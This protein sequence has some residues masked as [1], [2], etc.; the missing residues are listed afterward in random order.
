MKNGGI[1]EMRIASFIKKF[2]KTYSIVII[3]NSNDSIKKYSLKAPF[4]KI[5]AALLIIFTLSLSAYCINLSRDSANIKEV[6]KEA[7]QKQ[8]ETL[9]L[10]IVEQNKALAESNN[11]IKSLQS[12][13]TENKKKIKEFSKMYMEI[14]NKYISKSNRG[15]T[16]KSKSESQTGLDLL[17]L[18]S[19]IQQINKNLDSD[20]DLA[21]DL[22][23]SETK[24]ER[25]VNALPTSVPALGKVT[26]PFGMRMHPIKKVYKTHEGVD[27]SSSKGDP[28]H[29][30][31][32]GIVVYSGY[33]SG[34]GKYVIIDHKNGYSTIYAHA[35][36]LL[37]KSGD[38]V[39]K[40]QKIALVGSTGLS[41][42]PHLHF[43]IRIDNIPVNPI[44][45]VNF[46]SSN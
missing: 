23:T 26:S 19:F 24:L 35:S 34:Y 38:K 45:Y 13:D 30:S 22:K 3:P 37:V 7:L 17:K 33:S 9:S 31:A 32:S 41:T 11:Q 40:S 28:I 39:D 27:I 12:T 42:G 14:A 20:E 46:S 4:V 5:S 16:A 36:E 18:N 8:V 6:S 44:E 25:I 15:T 29:A 1:Y 21:K 10:S 2:N 43:E